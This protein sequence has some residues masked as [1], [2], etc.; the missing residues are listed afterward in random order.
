[1]NR[2]PVRPPLDWS[3]TNPLSMLLLGAAIAVLLREFG[4]IQY[5][6]LTSAARW[7][8]ILCA[9]AVIAGLAFSRMCWQLAEAG[10]PAR[11]A[12]SAQVVNR[13]LLEIYLLLAALAAFAGLMN[14]RDVLMGGQSFTEA[15]LGGMVE[16]FQPTGWGMLSAALAGMPVIGMALWLT[17]ENFLKRKFIG[18][19]LL[20]CFVTHLLVQLASG[21]R[22]GFLLSFLFVFLVFWTFRRR[23]KL[24]LG[25]LYTWFWVLGILV[26]CFTVVL[27]G[28][29][30]IEREA[31]RE[32]D[33]LESID[34]MEA[35]FFVQVAWT[36]TEESPLRLVY[37]LFLL[38][39]THPMNE[40]ARLI[41]QVPQLEPFWGSYNFR[42]PVLLLARFGLSDFTPAAL[43]A[44]VRVGT[45][46]GLPGSLFLDFGYYGAILASLVVGVLAGYAFLRAM[47]RE[48]VVWVLIS[49]YGALVLF[50]SPIISLPTIS[51]GFPMLAATLILPMLRWFS[52][53]RFSADE[54]AST[55]RSHAV[56]K[57]PA[58]NRTTT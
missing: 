53:C 13:R 28:T 36:A 24:R 12:P 3:L 8:L 37:Y 14:T 32:R 7:L 47:R 48:E 2:G 55:G 27:F 39:L 52:E 21:G 41:D 31:F 26:V 10:Q 20:M 58:E 34:N 35:S 5:P 11:P 1:M 4:G 15:R 17:D 19:G 29:I 38:Y 16:G 45:Y 23:H 51:I 46:F 40:V 54:S 43:Q 33:F 50:V 57:A 25:R 6:P 18:A 56:S 9:V 22:W 42:L 44:I 30:F 49:L